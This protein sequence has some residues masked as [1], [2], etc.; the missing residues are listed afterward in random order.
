MN[1]IRA[2]KIANR[3]WKETGERAKITVEQGQTPE[4]FGTNYYIVESN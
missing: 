1:P 2:M 4:G 3:I